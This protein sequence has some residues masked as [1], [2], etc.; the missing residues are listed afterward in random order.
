[1]R[2]ST[3]AMEFV[4]ELAKSRNFPWMFAAFV[5]L[6]HASLLFLG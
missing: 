2:A 5:R 6:E 4:P 1:M 3:G